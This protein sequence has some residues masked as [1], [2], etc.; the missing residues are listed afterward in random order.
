MGENRNFNFLE[1]LKPLHIRKKAENCLPAA[2]Q[3][4]AKPQVK[5]LFDNQIYSLIFGGK[6]QLDNIKEDSCDEGM[7]S[8]LLTAVNIQKHFGE[9]PCF[10]ASFSKENFFDS[11]YEKFNT[12]PKEQQNI[13]L[14][15]EFK[16]LLS[17]LSCPSK[18]ML[19]S[20][21]NEVMREDYCVDKRQYTSRKNILMIKR[22]VISN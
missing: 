22:G 10:E 19:E 20:F 3:F 6:W 18:Y 2:F 9:C 15:K 16:S 4:W 17:K 8:L 1:S 12:L 7:L 21:T 5:K 11:S 13:S 14:L